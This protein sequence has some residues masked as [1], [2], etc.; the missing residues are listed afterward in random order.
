MSDEPEREPEHE[1]HLTERPTA[2]LVVMF[3][4]GL[5]GFIVVVSVV[6]VVVVALTQPSAD[7]GSESNAL[8]DVTSTL[9]AAVIGFIAGKGQPNGNG[10]A[11]GTKRE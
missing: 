9:I 3:L 6:S 1:H 7:L 10:K 2:D 5:I 11:N 4:A 8:A